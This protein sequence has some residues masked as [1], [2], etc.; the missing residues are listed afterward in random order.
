MQFIRRSLGFWGV[1]YRCLHRRSCVQR[2][3]FDVSTRKESGDDCHVRHF[4]CNFIVWSIYGIRL[5]LD[6]VGTRLCIGSLWEPDVVHRR[7][8]FESLGRLLSLR[9]QVRNGILW[10]KWKY[11]CCVLWEVLWRLAYGVSRIRRAKWKFVCNSWWYVSEWSE[12]NLSASRNPIQTNLYRYR[13]DN[14]RC[15]EQRG[16]DRSSDD[17]YYEFWNIMGSDYSV[18]SAG[19]TLSRRWAGREWNFAILISSIVHL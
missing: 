5:R 7:R 13:R 16:F 10:H 11:G 6:G 4:T 18:R 17:R 2:K 14:W 9:G 1:R 19:C 12:S 15:S 3:L 8:R